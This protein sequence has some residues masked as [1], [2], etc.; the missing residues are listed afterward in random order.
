MNVPFCPVVLAMLAAQPRAQGAV[1]RE[2]E[3][4]GLVS[5][6]PADEVATVTLRR[7]EHARLVYVRRRLYRVSARGRRE[8]AFQRAVTQALARD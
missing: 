5:G 2:L 7:L 8:L 6:V 3:R 4:R 1:A